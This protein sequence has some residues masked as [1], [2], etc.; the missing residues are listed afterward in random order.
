MSSK[1]SPSG[2]AIGHGRTCYLLNITARNGKG[3]LLAP[4]RLS[5]RQRSLKIALPRR[6]PLLHQPQGRVEMAAGRN[7]RNIATHRIGT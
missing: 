3:E 7:H 6:P 2:S 5:R 1:T 4:G